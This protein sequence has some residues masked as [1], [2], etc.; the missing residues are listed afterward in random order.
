MN[1]QTMSKQR[2]FILVA[3][4]V[5]IITMFLPWIKFTMFGVTEDSINGMHGKG[6]VVFLC[7]IVAGIVAYL[8]DQTKILD[9]TFWF[10]AL[11]CRTLSTVL[12]IWFFIEVKSN[13]EYALAELRFG[14]YLA[15]L[16]AIG[17]LL[18][19]YL[20]KAPDDSIKSGFDSLKDSIDQ[21]TKGGN[22]DTV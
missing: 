4:A 3:V 14:F 12:M 7:F 1:F 22:A 17:V 8:G 19:A 15:A 2:K 16:S 6:V 21:K 11:L 13:D 18:S 9:K 20:F 5:G 10:I